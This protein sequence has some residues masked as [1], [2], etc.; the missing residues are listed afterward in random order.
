VLDWAIGRNVGFSKF[1]S[2]GKQ[3]R[4]LGVDILEFL[5]D[6]PSTG[7]SSVRRKH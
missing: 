6:D 4:R 7:S 2:L 3:G 1:V 5:A